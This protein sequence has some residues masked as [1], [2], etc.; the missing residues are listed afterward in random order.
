MSGL[1]AVAGALVAG[2]ADLY[3]TTR[4]SAAPASTSRV[5]QPAS[6]A[7][8][9]LTFCLYLHVLWNVRTLLQKGK[10]ENAKHE[11]DWQLKFLI[12]TTL[13]SPLIADTEHLQINRPPPFRAVTQ[14]RW[15]CF[16]CSSALNRLLQVYIWFRYEVDDV[17]PSNLF[18]PSIVVKYIKRLKNNGSLDPMASRQNSIRS[19][20][21]WFFSIISNLHLSLQ[22]GI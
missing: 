7:A 17:M 1:L 10:T 16:V 6:A 8:A 4:A 20:P 2:D 11:I 9:T 3:N 5:S 13:Q 15:K 19:R 21:T 12:A 14:P 22:F 18:T